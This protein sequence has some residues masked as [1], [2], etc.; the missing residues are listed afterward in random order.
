LHFVEVSIGRLLCDIETELRY[1]VTG[2]VSTKDMSNKT[3]SELVER[4]AAMGSQ[5]LVLL[6]EA[7]ALRMHE[8]MRSNCDIQDVV[9]LTDSEHVTVLCDM[10]DD[11]YDVYTD[12]VDEDAINHFEG[13]GTN[14][15]AWEVASQ[16]DSHFVFESGGE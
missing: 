4:S 10:V 11:V 7:V 3:F 12:S 2:E 5:A 8:L 9:H 6:R 15:I 1:Q 16:L 13:N 14:D